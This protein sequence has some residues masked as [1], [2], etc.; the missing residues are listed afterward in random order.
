MTGS[1]KLLMLW[2]LLIVLTVAS[3]LLA[4][5]MPLTFGLVAVVLLVTAVKAGVLVDY[6]MGLKNAP[7]LWRGLLMAYAPVLAV[8]ISLTYLF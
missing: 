5:P 6:F 8:L 4:E 7:W 2:L 3:A 1:V